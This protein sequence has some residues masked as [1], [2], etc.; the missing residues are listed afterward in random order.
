[1][2]TSMPRKSVLLLLGGM[3]MIKMTSNKKIIP[4]MSKEKFTLTIAMTQLTP[5]LP[6]RLSLEP[7]KEA[8]STGLEM[9]SVTHPRIT[10]SAIMMVAIA[11]WRPVFQLN[12]PVVQLATLVSIPMLCKCRR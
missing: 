12:T 6:L 3:V 5:R 8:S 2:L 9:D 11:V 4:T 1:M 10:L 7:V